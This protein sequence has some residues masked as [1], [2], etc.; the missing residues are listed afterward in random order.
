MKKILLSLLILAGCSG[1]DSDQEEFTFRFNPPDTVRYTMGVVGERGTKI[2]ST[3]AIDT[4]LGFSRFVMVAK[5][6]GYEVISSTDSTRLISN[7][8]VIDDPIQKLFANAVITRQLDSNGYTTVVSGYQEIFRVLDSAFEPAVAKAVRQRLDPA[9][10][11]QKEAEEWNRSYAALVGRSCRLGEYSY[12]VEDLGMV[13]G[14]NLSYFTATVL[15]DTSRIDGQLCGRLSTVGDTDPNLLANLI[16]VPPE[17]VMKEFDLSDS[18]ALELAGSPIGS[19]MYTESIMEM[20]TMLL[21]SDKA[22]R[23][24]RQTLPDSTGQPETR[25]FFESQ[26]RQYVYQR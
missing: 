22:G 16:S 6:Q 26:S 10:L 17:Q 7:G 21:H 11:E 4:N 19:A 18:A 9:V 14:V 1:G 3:I 24:L 8:Q 20:E 12:S 5:G 2:G 13:S 15:V 23:E 25:I